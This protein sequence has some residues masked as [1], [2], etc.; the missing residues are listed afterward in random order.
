MIATC[1]HE[2]RFLDM[3]PQIRTQ[4]RFAFRDEPRSRRQELVSEVVAN[5]WAAFV[6]LVERGRIDIVYPTPLAQFA[7]RQVRDGRK[8][9]SRLN[10]RDVSSEYS[11][12]RKNFAVE[13]LD[14]FDKAKQEWKEVLVEDKHA[15]PAEIAAARIDFAAW[16]RLLPKRLRRIAETLAKGETTKKAAK[17]FR[18][19]Q[20]RISQLRRELEQN[21]DDFQG[22]FSFA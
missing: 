12:R 6:R 9:G 19:S 15:G 11:Q 20:G 16:L 10:V 8:V 13:T 4:A 18:V 1:P 21:W 5:C 3:L 2:D 7:I 14:R 17:R 22:G